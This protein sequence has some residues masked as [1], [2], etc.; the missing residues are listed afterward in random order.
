MTAIPCQRPGA[1][2]AVGLSRAD[3]A[4]AAW[5]IEPDGRRHRG[6]DAVLTALAW[7]LGCPAL[8]SLY[9]LPGLRQAADAVYAWVAAHRGRLPGVTPYCQEH[10]EECA[11]AEGPR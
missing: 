7:A 10:P 4:A 3:C 6:A 8:A 1:P 9:R 5:A 2:E 11:P